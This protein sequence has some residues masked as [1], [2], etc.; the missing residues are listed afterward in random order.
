MSFQYDMQ[1]TNCLDRDNVNAIITICIDG[2]SD[3]TML[4]CAD[5]QI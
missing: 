5:R 3:A 2:G 1:E 4:V